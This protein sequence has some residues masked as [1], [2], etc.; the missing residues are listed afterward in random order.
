[1]DGSCECTDGFE[2]DDCNTAGKQ[3]NLIAPTITHW[4]VFKECIISFFL[5]DSLQFVILLQ[6]AVVTEY[7][8]WMDLVN[9][10]MDLRAM[11]A[12]LQVNK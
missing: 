7:A 8:K 6:H 11:I 4:N 12:I 10:L 3:I 2:G 1:M 9:A 5:N